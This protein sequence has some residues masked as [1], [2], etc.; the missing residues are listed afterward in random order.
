MINVSFGENIDLPLTYIPT[1][2][3]ERFFYVSEDITVTLSDGYDLL[4][5]KGFET[6]LRSSPKI[7]WSIVPPYNKALLAYLI[8]DRL[9]CD[10]LGQFKHF[11]DKDGKLNI[12]KAK[13]FADNEMFIWSN[14]LAPEKKFENYLSY[15]IVKWFGKGMYMGKT[16]IPI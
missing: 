10:K 16:E 2:K 8:H 14:I 11:M 9:W 13:K 5:P 12:H 7:F 1:S 3:G 15:I 4:I 6:E